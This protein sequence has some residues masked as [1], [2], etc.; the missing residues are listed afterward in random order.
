STT[1]ALAT[2]TG[3]A[4][5]ADGKR[6]RE[7]RALSQ[8]ALDP[9]ATAVELDE[10]ARQRQPES[11]SLDLLVRGADLLELLEHPLLILGRDPHAGIDH[12][13]L[14]GAV[15]DG[16][17][18]VDP[19]ALRRELQRVGQQIEKDLL[20]LALVCADHA[21]AL[22]DDAVERDGAASRSLPH[23]GERAVDGGRQM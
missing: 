1:S 13:D 9:D 16:G 14:D 6:E 22:A 15:G 12:G 7:G 8:L 4:G 2:E 5:R 3:S 19:A 21:H 23:E 10:L 11:R 20:D 18:D 17:A